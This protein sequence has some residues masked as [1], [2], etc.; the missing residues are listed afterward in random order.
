MKGGR[1]AVVLASLGPGGAERI[2]VRLAGLLAQRGFAVDVVVPAPQS[3]AMK[4][5]VPKEVALVEL[6]G[7]HYFESLR[8]FHRIFKTKNIFL[9]PWA[10][11][12]FFWKLFVSTRSLT[13]YIGRRRPDLLLTA[14]YNAMTLT[15]NF[16]AGRPSRVVVTEHTLL[17][18]HLRRQVAPVRVCFSTMCRLFYPKAD[19]VVGVSS[20]VAAD[21]AAHFRLPASRVG[22]IYNPVVGS[23]LKRKAEEVCHHPWLTDKTI[24]TLI[25][26]ARLSPEK[27]FD[28]LLEA[29]SLLRRTTPVRLLVLGDGPDRG[30]LERR[31]AELKVEADVDWMGMTP[32]PLPLVREADALVLS[33]FYEGLPTVLIEALYVGTTPVATDAPGGIREILEDGRYGYIVP[34]RDAPALSEGMLKALRQPMPKGM[35]RER[36]GAFSE[37]RAVDAYLEL[38]G[39]IGVTRD[40]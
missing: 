19:R 29:F 38:F 32:N 20:A 15:A 27:D 2:M 39:M 13:H 24:P 12:V 22:H 18:E 37:K 26:V 40:A 11:V 21:L 23:A 36:A 8:L 25:S 16:L 1:I 31:A 7:G 17:S 3:D 34:V 28:T 33:T 4:A 6:D 9:L 14:H 5:G 30:R 35:L 10:F